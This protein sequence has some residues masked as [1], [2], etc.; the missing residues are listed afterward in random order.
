[1][2]VF[3]QGAYETTPNTMRDDLRTLASFPLSSPYGGGETTTAGVLAVS[4]ANNA[5]VDWVKVE[6]RDAATPTTIVVTAAGLVQR[7]GDVVSAA[8]GVSPLSFSGLTTGNYYVV[9]DH[10]NHLAA[11]VASPVALSLTPTSVDF[12]SSGTVTYGVQARKSV[13][14]AFPAELLW[15]GDVTFNGQIKYAGANNDRDPVLGLIGGSVPTS[16]VSGYYN[17]DVNMNGQVKYAGSNNDRDMIL[18]TI[19]GSVPTAVKL[20]QLP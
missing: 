15:S 3:L 17:E 9:V 1:M 20:E 13:S 10:R 5:I 2:K 4:D 8:D 6:L 12:T 18:Q 16:V 7:D 19:G 11:M 14:G